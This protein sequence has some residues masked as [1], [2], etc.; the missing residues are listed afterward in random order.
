M[1]NNVA[2]KLYRALQRTN[3]YPVMLLHGSEVYAD[4]Y[5]SRNTNTAAAVPS[6]LNITMTCDTHNNTLC[7]T[8][9]NATRLSADKIRA[10]IRDK[11]PWLA[12]HMYICHYQSIWGCPYLVL[13]MALDTDICDHFAKRVISLDHML[14]TLFG[15]PDG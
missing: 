6:P 12:S 5:I 2:N 7:T 8:V 15:L 3:K 13:T 10:T 14:R 9:T 11:C 1:A 4:L